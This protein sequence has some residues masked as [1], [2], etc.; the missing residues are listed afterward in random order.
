MVS[1]GAGGGDSPFFVDLHI[2]AVRFTIRTLSKKITCR[3][4]KKKQVPFLTRRIFAMSMQKKKKLN[5]TRGRLRTLGKKYKRQDNIR[6]AYIIHR[7][8]S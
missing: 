2:H 1:A 3:M 6:V 8:T 7:C 4:E 5:Q